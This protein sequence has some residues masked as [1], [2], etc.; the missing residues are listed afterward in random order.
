MTGRSASGLTDLRT[1][2][3]NQD[4]EPAWRRL[5]RTTLGKVRLAAMLAA[6][7]GTVPELFQV[8]SDHP[9]GRRAAGTAAIVL[10]LV[11]FVVTYARRR[12]TLLDP[13]VIGL[14]V[15]LGGISLRDPMAVI[16]VCIYAVAT[17]SLYGSHRAAL[18]RLVALL[19][20]FPAT[21]AVSP[22]SLGRYIP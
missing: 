3:D 14:A 11:D 8:S 13:L 2:S 16:G 5:P 7:V 4:M 17:Q 22:I 10:L 12:A 21:I 9:A 19:V 15:F 18:V 6:C 20:A 1:A